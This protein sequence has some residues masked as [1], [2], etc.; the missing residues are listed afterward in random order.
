MGMAKGRSV[1]LAL[2]AGGARGLAHIPVLEAFDELG[3]SPCRI[4]GSSIG[5][6]IGAAYASGLSGRDIRGHTLDALGDPAR[7]VAKLMELRPRR[8]RDV[9]ARGVLSL[10]Q[11]DAERVLDLFLPKQVAHSF[12]DLSIPLS[13]VTT[14]FYGC[15]ELEFTSGPL[16]KAVA[17]SIALPALFKPVTLHGRILVDG[18]MVNPLPVD[19]LSGADIIVAVD[20]VGGPEPRGGRQYPSPRD[21]LF[22]ATQILMQSIIAEKLRHERAD[23]LLRPDI[24]LFRVLDFLK[25]RAILKAADPV[26]EKIKRRLDRLLSAG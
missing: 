19:K 21:S 16:R 10:A 17:A 24:N 8:F 26:R 7:V 14:D 25:A 23:I 22:G 15:C 20:V 12:A 1:G 2:G 13:V 3:I 9:S 6:V 4:A 11:F 18:G 5:A